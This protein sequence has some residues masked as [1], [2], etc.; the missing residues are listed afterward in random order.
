VKKDLQDIFDYHEQTKHSQSRYARSLGYMDWANQPDPFRSYEGA[1]KI[2]LPLATSH[3]TPPYHLIF[4]SQV[5]TAPL[6]LESLSQFL[7]FS[8][9]TSAIKSNGI[10]E[11]A[12]RCNA[13]SGNLHPSEVYLLLPP[14][15]GVS[16]QS[17]IAHY[18]PKD[19]SLEILSSFGTTLFDKLAEG[20][21]FLLVSSIVYREVWKYGERAFRYTQL[22]AGHAMRATQVSGLTLGWHSCLIDSLSDLKLNEIFGF[23]QEQRFHPNERESADMLMLFSPKSSHTDIDLNSLTQTHFDS[24]ANTLASNHQKWP[25]ISLIEEV[26]NSLPIQRK[27]S[28]KLEILREPSR[29]AKSVILQRRSAQMMDTER[30]M[31]SQQ[32]FLTLLNSTQESFN[33]YQNSVDLVIF[34][35]NVEGLESGLYLYMRQ[36]DSLEDLK[37]SMHKEFVFQELFAKLYL[38]QKGDF[39]VIAKNISCN[40]NIVSDGA[41]SLGMLASFSQEILEYGAHRYK[42]LYWECGAIGQQLYLEATSQGLSATGI[43]CFLDDM[44]HELLGLESNK[45]QSLYHF[46]IG[47]A[48]VDS[49]ILTKE[50]YASREP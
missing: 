24:I 9:G 30:T 15:K 36:E 45:Y 6:V 5:P 29:D 25:M 42:E 22:D 7:Q 27:K 19:H 47:R 28:D 11:W 12:L 33:G 40:Q 44:F 31:I 34:V 3:N 8:M 16:E 43:G 1:Q 32:V 13:S 26:T 2:P 21:F 39:R 14:I 50:P 35:H 37:Q 23:D 48:L 4:T 10:D 20:S 49:R 38:L 46:T 18:A 41:F 17:C